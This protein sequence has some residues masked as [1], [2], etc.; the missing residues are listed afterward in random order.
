VPIGY[1]TSVVVV[2]L[3]TAII[4]RAP[5]RPVGVARA[6]FV[7]THWVNEYP[8]IA[9]AALAAVTVPVLAQGDLTSAGGWVLFGV[10]VVT[11]LGLLRVVQRAWLAGAVVQSALADGLADAWPAGRAEPRSLGVLRVLR[12]VIAPF[13]VR[14]RAVQRIANLAY[15][16]AG[17]GNL[18]DLYRLRDAP[19]Q[20]M[21][22]LIHFHGGHFQIGR[23]SREALPLIYRLASEGWLCI[24]A[25]Y[26]L[27]AAGRFPN[28]L[29]DAKAVIAWARTQGVQYGADP[30]LIVVAGGSA[31]GHLASMAALTPNESAFQPSA[32]GVDTSVAA[33]VCLYGYY[34]RRACGAPASSPEDYISPQAPPFLVAAGDNDNQ[35]DVSHADDFVRALRTRSAAPVVYFR[36]PGAQHAF[37]LLRSLRF[38]EVVDGVVT[39]L[40][41]VRRHDG[42]ASPRRV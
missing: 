6:T 18:M 3:Y 42:Q 19:A 21:P 29:V 7:T 39:F 4:L 9:L 24:S 13:P 27:R 34:G 38:D 12:D 26:R 14:P 1:L 41:W 36:L 11:A 17:R 28:S 20:P 10:A 22:V 31:G 25:N 2:A 40:E 23:K 35:I 37:D 16:D 5:R 30:S 8:F 33:A 32:A 15:G